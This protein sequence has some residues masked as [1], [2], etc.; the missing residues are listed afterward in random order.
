MI[1]DF[2]TYSKLLSYSA[3]YYLT[4]EP[5]ESIFSKSLPLLLSHIQENKFKAFEYHTSEEV[6]KLILDMADMLKQRFKLNF[7]EV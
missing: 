5:E 1:K 4:S 3:G 7:K 6:Y 2:K